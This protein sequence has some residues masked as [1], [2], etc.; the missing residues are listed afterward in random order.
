M[1]I[2]NCIQSISRLHSKAYIC[3]VKIEGCSKLLRM[4][5]SFPSRTHPSTW[6]LISRMWAQC[7]FGKKEKL[8]EFIRTV[9]MMNKASL[10]QDLMFVNLK[11]AAVTT[12]LFNVFFFKTKKI[13][14]VSFS[15]LSVVFHTFTETRLPHI[16]V[17]TTQV[18]RTKTS[19]RMIF[20]KEYQHYFPFFFALWRVPFLKKM[21]VKST[22]LCGLVIHFSI[23]EL[24]FLPAE[25]ED[26][27]HLF[28]CCFV[29]ISFLFFCVLFF[30][31]CIC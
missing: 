6:Y 20:L 30:L 29:F 4:A 23:Q 5:L 16:L 2:C 14:F 26:M 25:N 3:G 22:S 17:W 21:I 19:V 24:V 28:V 27:S 13:C 31:C 7:L 9:E 1:F 11:G 8:Y 12:F 18:K 10:D 15:T